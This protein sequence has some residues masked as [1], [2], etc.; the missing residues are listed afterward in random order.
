MGMNIS[1]GFSTCPNDTFIFGALV[2]GKIDTRGYTFEVTMADVEELN[3]KA[4]K[5]ELDVTKLSMFAYARFHENYLILDA[6]SALGHNNG[7]L[8]I[9]KKPFTLADVPDLTIAIPGRNTTAFFL[10]SSL[11]P[12][13]KNTT[14]ILFSD[15]EKAIDTNTVDAGLIIHETRFTYEQH[16]FLKI[17]DLGEMWEKTTGFP[18]PLGCIA[19]KR[20]LPPEVMNDINDLIHQ[21]L[22][23]AFSHPAETMDFCRKHAQEMSEDVMRKHIELYVNNFSL[24]LG[25]DG[26]SAIMTMFQ[27]AEALNLV[28]LSAKEL[29]F[30]HS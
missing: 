10:L 28:S 23:Y 7:P 2:N 19:I 20:T 14:E 17:A 25:E 8:L 24:S 1:L 4:S 9:S 29:F 22:E 16:G 13:A 6:G 18:V 11:F 15:I 5:H 26:R 30:K 21:S 3:Q 12:P 27:K